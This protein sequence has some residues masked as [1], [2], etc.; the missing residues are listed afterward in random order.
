MLGVQ[1]ADLDQLFYHRAELTLGN[2]HDR[3]FGVGES[4]ATAIVIRFLGPA[5]LRPSSFL[6]KPDQHADSYCG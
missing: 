4:K 2:S 3:R 5:P 1:K 6:K